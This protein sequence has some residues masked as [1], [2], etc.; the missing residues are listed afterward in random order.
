MKKILFVFLIVVILGVSQGNIGV[1]TSENELPDVKPT[2]I[3]QN[4]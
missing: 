1:L 4:S 3:N 2:S